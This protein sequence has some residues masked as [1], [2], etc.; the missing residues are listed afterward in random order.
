MTVLCW[1]N[2][3]TLYSHLG[4]FAI[5]ITFGANAVVLMLKLGCEDDDAS[6]CLVNASSKTKIELIPG[7]RLAEWSQRIFSKK[8]NRQ[9]IE[10]LIADLQEE[11]LEATMNKRVYHSRWIRIRYGLAYIQ[12]V[13]VVLGFNV[14]KTVFAVAKIK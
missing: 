8:I 14:I 5:A 1:F 13:S 12:A 4:C 2:M 9:T 10:P 7:T 6:G 11:W 3:D